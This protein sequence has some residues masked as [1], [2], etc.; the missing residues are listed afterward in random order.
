MTEKNHLYLDLLCALLKRINAH[1]LFFQR[2]DHDYSGIMP[3]VREILCLTAEIVIKTNEEEN[4]DPIPD[5]II[6]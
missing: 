1:L 6:Y 5:L 2:D 4:Q 3:K